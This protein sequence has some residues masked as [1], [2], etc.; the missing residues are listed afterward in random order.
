MVGVLLKSL[1]AFEGLLFITT[2]RVASFDPA[3]LSRVTLSIRYGSLK[4]SGR[5]AVWKNVLTRAGVDAANFDVVE[6]AARGGSGRD[7][8]AACRLALTLSYFRE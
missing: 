5:Q 8:N 2:N 6:L 3:A 4:D 7:I 1:D